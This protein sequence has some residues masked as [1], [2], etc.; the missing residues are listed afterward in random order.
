M[1][2]TLGVTGGIGSGK[3]SV[4]RILEELGARVFYADAEGKR[5]LVEDPTA[6][7]QI[8]E[9]FGPESYHADGSLNRKYLSAHVFGDAKRVE[10]INAIVHPRVFERFASARE[11]A[12]A[13]GVPLLVNEAAL[14]FETGSEGR[15]DAVAVI[16]APRDVRI[17]RVVERDDVSPDAVLARM[18]HQLPPEELV[19]RADFV[20]DNSG[21]LG[22]LRRQVEDVYRAMTESSKSAS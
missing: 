22:E 4:C 16:D 17:Q 21:D 6:R 20:I 1:T 10:L 2:K 7:A 19:R 15:L 3:S 8:I 14:I 9:A 13:E 5:V 18:E 11:Q 12:E